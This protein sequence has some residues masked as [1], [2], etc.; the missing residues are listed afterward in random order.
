MALH[1]QTYHFISSNRIFFPIYR[2]IITIKAILMLLLFILQQLAHRSELHSVVKARVYTDKENLSRHTN[3][4][5]WGSDTLFH[6]VYSQEHEK[7]PERESGRSAV[8][9]QQALCCW[10]WTGWEEGL[11]NRPSISL[12]LPC[13]I[14]AHLRHTAW[15]VSW[16]FPGSPEAVAAI[17]H[18]IFNLKSVSQVLSGRWALFCTTP[19]Q[20]RAFPLPLPCALKL[21][22]KTLQLSFPL[23]PWLPEEQQHCCAGPSI[24]PGQVGTPL[25]LEHRI[26]ILTLPFP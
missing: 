21:I 17:Q 18:Y 12:L 15:S 11:S 2:K 20:Q 7:L 22:H 1:L 23:Y 8:C 14:A 24:H 4:P 16:H 19:A 6:I 25:P 3:L 10:G 5:G 26:R 9:E 13:I